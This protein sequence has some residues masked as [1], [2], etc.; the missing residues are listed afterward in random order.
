VNPGRGPA[1]VLVDVAAVGAARAPAASGEPLRGWTA[2]LELAP[3]SERVVA[4]ARSGPAQNDAV[5]VL[6][7]AGAVAVFESVL[8]TGTQ[9][10]GHHS[11]PLLSIP[12]QSPCSTGAATRSYLASGS[13]EDE[14]DVIV[15]LFD[16]TATQAVAAIRVSTESGSVT[17]PALQGL[18]VKPY[19]LQVFDIARSVVQQ[20]SMAIT[21]TTTAGS[22]AA[23][24]SETIASDA[25]ATTSASGSALVIGIGAPQDRWVLTPGLGMAR[26]TVGVRV[27]DPGP[28][29]AIVTISSPVKGR[30]PIEITQVVPAG[31]VRAIDLPAPPGSVKKEP[32]APAR[33]HGA[34]PV[35]EGPI[36]VATARGVGV[37]VS[38]IAALTV[39]SHAETVAF[40]AVSS[41]PANNW[42]VPAAA[43]G[44]SASGGIVISNPGLE[45][46]HVEVAGFSPGGGAAST[47]QFAKLTIPPMASATAPLFLPASEASFAGVLVTASG[48]VVAEQ[49]FFA[50]GTPHDPVPVTPVPVEGIPV[51]G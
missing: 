51:I 45:T 36:V 34:S 22:V 5:S 23:G 18:I 46:V 1:R 14:S 19:S 38:R 39:G 9:E 42:V 47:T 43:T 25:T 4:L 16:P 13:T 21:V 15:S 44:T 6:S 41:V 28:H 32:N 12:E 35:A 26:R 30:S 24:A 49:D 20:A 3:L 17:P 10:I 7:T 50:L 8:R 40:A 27:Y 31:E 48:Q 11:E 33:G 2:R 29:A 37:L